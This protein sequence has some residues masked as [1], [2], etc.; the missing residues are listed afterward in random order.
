MR[1]S[2]ILQL[3]GDAF[4]KHLIDDDD[5]DGFPEKY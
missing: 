1:T 5:L 2:I 3:A 4:N